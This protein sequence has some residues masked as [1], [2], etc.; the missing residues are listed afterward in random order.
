[1]NG[2]PA[3]SGTFEQNER[4]VAARSNY[5]HAGGVTGTDREVKWKPPS[6]SRGLVRF[7]GSIGALTRVD[8]SVPL[9]YTE[10]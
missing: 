5:Q 4:A 2:S 6:R 1:M 10:D 8:A 3:E 7:R 9:H